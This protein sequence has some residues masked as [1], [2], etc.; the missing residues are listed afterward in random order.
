MANAVEG[1]MYSPTHV[2]CLKMVVDMLKNKDGQGFF[3]GNQHCG[4]YD[5]MMRKEK[6]SRMDDIRYFQRIADTTE[7]SIIESQ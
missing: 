7:S 2:S 5:E 3:F 6:C 1:E 4:L